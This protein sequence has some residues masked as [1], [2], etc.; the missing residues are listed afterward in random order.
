MTDFTFAQ[1]ATALGLTPSAFSYRARVG[2]VP[3]YPGRHFNARMVTLDVLERLAG[4]TFNNAEIARLL[5]TKAQPA[6]K[7][8]RRRATRRHLAEAGI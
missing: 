7:E 1:A 5:A 8:A 3:T 4:R 2:N 6:G